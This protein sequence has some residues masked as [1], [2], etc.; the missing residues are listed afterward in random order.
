MKLRSRQKQWNQLARHDP[1]WAI[2]ASPGKRNR[3]WD[4]DEF[5]ATGRH[6]IEAVMRGIEGLGY[7]AVRGRALDFGCGIGRNTQALADWFEHVTG[8]DI[9][10][11]ML[12]LAQQHN[13]APARCEY[14]LN[15]DGDLRTFPDAS[16]DFV[17]SRLVL[18]HL[19]AHHAR[20]HVREFLRILRPSGLVLFQLPSR[21]H[22]RPA[23]QVLASRAYNLLAGRILRHPRVVEMN[24]VPREVIIRDVEEVGGRILSV[25]NDDGAGPTWEN[26]LYAVTK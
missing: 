12:D 8:V 21:R 7:P 13:R 25:R 26:Y 6:E 19:P 23:W 15:A 22:P 20:R 10:H 1:F 18:Q 2:L 4:P 16:F 3:R 14:I 9:S 5:F 24:G 11:A 17:Y